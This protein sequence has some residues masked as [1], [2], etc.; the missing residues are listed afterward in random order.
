MKKYL[1]PKEG[2]F[3]KANLHTHSTVSDGRLSPEELKKAYKDLGYSILAYT[4]HDVMISQMHLRDEEFL[5][6]IGIEYDVNRNSDGPL[7]EGNT[8]HFGFIALDENM[9]TQI[10][11]HREKY[12][13]N[14]AKHSIPL[15]K[16]DESVPDY[17]R[18]YTPECITEMMRAGRD[19][20]FFVIYN[21]PTWS[22]ESYNQYISYDGMHAM[23]IVN[24]ISNAGTSGVF[25]YNDRVYDDMLRAGKRI[26]C[27]A[28]DDAH[29]K[30]APGTPRCDIGGAYIMV[31]AER[32]DYPSVAK[33][34]KEGNFYSSE[35]PEI[36]ALWY[37]DGKICI[38]SSPADRI[39]FTTYPARG[40]AVRDVDGED[41]THAEFELNDRHAFVRVTVIDK[42]GKRAY[43][44]AYFTDELKTAE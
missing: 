37:E 31:K 27:I 15:V 40:N 42:A 35:G 5:P 6:L 10:L 28:A 8:C 17:E 38:D 3:Y 29:A 32:L 39:V 41:I 24:N 43:T 44:N 7:S 14:A 16:F 22:Q 33:A 11:W 12:V 1:L 34:L 4:D 25:E 19:A 13:P 18:T 2:F 30:Y 36:N 20:N 9:D 26:F 23:E 21:H